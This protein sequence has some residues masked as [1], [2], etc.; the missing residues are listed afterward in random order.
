MIPVKL[1]LTNFI[2]HSDTEIDFTDISALCLYGDNGAG[3]TSII[4]G[5]LYALYSRT[6]RGKD[7]SLIRS[8]ERKLQVE[9]LFEVEGRKYLVKKEKEFG[10][11]KEAY[12]YLVEDEATD[13]L[14]TGE[15]VDH[16]IENMLGMDYNT[17]TS[18]C[19][20]LQDNAYKFIL[21]TPSDRYR[22][23]F[24][25]LGLEV[26]QDYK[27]TASSLKR[28][29][30]GKVDLLENQIGEKKAIVEGKQEIKKGLEEVKDALKKLSERKKQTEI[31]Y[32]KGEKELSSL[33]AS[34]SELQKQIKADLPEEILKT[35]DKVKQYEKILQKRFVV[36]SAL[37]EKADLNQ[38]MTRLFEEEKEIL[39]KY[40]WIRD[41]LFSILQAESNVRSSLDAAKS[42]AE[43]C[44][45]EAEKNKSRL[46]EFQEVSKL[47]DV[48]PCKAE[49]E[50]ASCMLIY[51]AV[52]SRKEIPTLQEQLKQLSAKADEYDQIVLARKKELDDIT[53]IRKQ[54]EEDERKLAKQ[55]KEVQTVKTKLQRRLEELEK[56]CNLQSQ[57]ASAEKALE[58]E[59][60]KLKNLEQEME[61]IKQLKAKEEQMIL[62]LR[63]TERM[64]KTLEQ[65]VYQL[66]VEE[67]TLKDK[68]SG[69]EAKLKICEEQEKEVK[70]LTLQLDEFRKK[71]F[72]YSLLEEAYDKIPRI[73]FAS[74]L[75]AF[76]DKVNEILNRLSD[77]GMQIELVTER[78]AKTTKAVKNTLDIIVSDV[79]GE[80]PIGNFSGGEK[81]RLALATTVAL[82]ELASQ[83]GGRKVLTLVVDEPPGLDMQGHKDFAMTVNQLIKEGMFAKCIV[84]SHSGELID[85]FQ[86]KIRV[87][88]N[89]E[90]ISQVFVEKL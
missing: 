77:T 79:A 5:I 49:G 86:Q 40:E 10:K 50:F 19:F 45:L 65:Q 23:L 74:Y 84:I 31:N 70:S 47:V 29:M 46:D 61:R 75:A 73:M 51:N 25:I 34:L 3:K 88:K 44:L 54:V 85:E 7:E 57:I 6:S 66:E 81:T 83:K 14:A 69:L 58:A 89:G 35:K 56:L 59:M 68:A 53:S 21:A 67:K 18:T 38:E 60:E 36:Q 39:K 13:L 1:K 11:P 72:I 2:S 8:G 90:G 22:V 24:D 78:Q 26:Y 17:F 42:A 20:L 32:I 30:E 71:A 4:D 87:E 15:R 33:S 55:L 52:K 82:S 64:V 9:L 76:E 28:E 27:K 16:Y 37:Q 43:R 80:R 12:L 62:K 41:K 63:E 48:V